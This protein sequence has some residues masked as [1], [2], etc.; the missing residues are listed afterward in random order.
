MITLENIL[1]AADMLDKE[2]KEAIVPILK[3][4]VSAY[5]SLYSPFEDEYVKK[6]LDRH[7]FSLEKLDPKTIHIES[8]VNATKN[9]IPENMIVYA[10][11]SQSAYHSGRLAEILASKRESDAYEL[12]V[13]FKK[14]F[15]NIRTQFSLFCNNSSKK[16]A[17]YVEDTISKVMELDRKDTDQFNALFGVAQ[18]PTGVK[19]TVTVENV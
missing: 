9:S 13:S 18:G 10:G 12:V 8:L 5:N 15:I 19:I 1:R 7:R 4:F 6:V 16:I 14:S 17:E 11:Y 3:E 2:Y